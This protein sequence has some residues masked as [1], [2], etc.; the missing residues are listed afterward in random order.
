MENRL[1]MEESESGNIA[2]DKW[3]EFFS[4]RVVAHGVEG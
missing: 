3:G 2:G 1:K 4:R